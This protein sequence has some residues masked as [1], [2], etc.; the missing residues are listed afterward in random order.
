FTEAEIRALVEAASA[1]GVPTAAHAHGEE[2]IKN[3]TRAGISSVEHGMFMDEEAA[4]LMVDHGTYWVPTASAVREIVEAGVEAG[5]PPEAVAK[6]EDAAER[7]EGAWEHALD[8]GVKIAMGTDAGTPFNDHGENALREMELLVEYGLSPTEALEAATVGG[9][10]LLGLDDVG[11]VAEGYVADLV[12]L[13][14]DPSEDAGAWR[15]VQQVYREG[16]QVV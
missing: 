4:D 14:A 2:G 7:F 5:I 13:D 6:A 12:V 10:D 15:T 16:E 8:A 3:A 11:K 1:K 9:A